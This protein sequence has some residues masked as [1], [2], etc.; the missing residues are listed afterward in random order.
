LIASISG[1]FILGFL[2]GLTGALAP[3]PTLIATINTSLKGGW[4][5]GPKVTLGHILVE[6]IM[7][8]FI[9]LGISVLIG[10][11]SFLIAGIGGVSLIV[12]GSLTILECRHATLDGGEKGRTISNPYMAGVVT[13]LTNPYFWIWWLTVGSAL[14]LSAYQGG[15]VL[16]GTF[17]IGHWAADLAWLTLVSASVHH[18]RLLLN[19]HMYRWILGACGVFLVVFGGYY[20]I[21]GFR[22]NYTL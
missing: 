4:S 17:I 5:V 16:A 15:L 13:S 12:F 7:V 10:T 8:C 14:L 18:G 2:I 20:L 19:Q 1:T 9:I 6:I 11:Y 21:S 3:G 22:L